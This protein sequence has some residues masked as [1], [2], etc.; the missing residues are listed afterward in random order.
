MNTN[1]KYIERLKKASRLS[2]GTR[3]ALM[4]WDNSIQWPD[5]LELSEILW[6]EE[7]GDFLDTL[8]RAG[9]KSFVCTYQGTGLMKNMHAFKAHGCT[10]I[11][12][13]TLTRKYSFEEK[14]IPG[15]RFS[16]N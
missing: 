12:L 3:K 6:Q 7:V 11:G 15:V 5:E 10:L 8:R 16:L 1:N 9:V 13:C 14:D 4:A 2:T